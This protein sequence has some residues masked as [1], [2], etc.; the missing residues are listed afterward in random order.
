VVLTSVY[1][2]FFLAESLRVSGVL[3][4]VTLGILVSA[5]VHTRMSHEGRHAHH[6]VLAQIGYTCNHVIFFSGGIISARFMWTANECIA[7][8]KSP[9]AWLELLLLYLCS[10][11][12]RALVIAAFS[13]ILTR[14]GYGITWKEGAI[15]VW[16]GLRGAVGLAMGLMVEHQAFVDDRI[17]ATVAFHVSG[18]V[19]LTLI[20]NGMTVDNLYRRLQVYPPNPFSMTYLRKSLCILEAECGK[21]ILERM[22]DDWFFE[23]IDFESILACVPNFSK[24]AFSEARVPYPDG[25]KSVKETLQSLEAGASHFK[26]DLQQ[27]NP[28]PFL[29]SPRGERLCSWDVLKDNAGSGGQLLENLWEVA[30]S[31]SGKDHVANVVNTGDQRFEYKA[32][33]SGSPHGLY[34]S[35]RPLS[36][37]SA[38]KSEKQYSFS[39]QVLSMEG[40][41]VVVGLLAKPGGAS[42]TAAEAV[43]ATE[44]E[45]LLGATPNSV[46]LDCLTGKAR[47]SGPAG[48]GE[49][50]QGDPSC[51]AA[52]STV[53]I[54]V[55][56]EVGCEWQI[57]FAIGDANCRK[58]A[59]CTLGPF[60]PNELYPAV[61]FCAR[62]G[63]LVKGRTRSFSRL[64]AG[65]S[66]PALGQAKGP[67]AAVHLSYEPQMATDEESL[68]HL[69]H[70]IFNMIT[71][72]YHEMHEH[73]L[74]GNEA[75]SWLTEAVESAV[76]CAECEVNS[77]RAKHF[78][79]LQEM[80]R[81]PSSRNCLEQL[82]RQVHSGPD[83]GKT[84]LNL[85]EPIIVEYLAIERYCATR[86]FFERFDSWS[87]FRRLDYHRMLVKVESLWAFVEAHEVVLRKYSTLE[88]FPDLAKCL[89]VIVAEAKHDLKILAEIKPRRYWYGKHFLALRVLMTK[90]RETLARFAQEGWLARDD[91][92]HLNK[93]LRDRVQEVEYFIPQLV[94][95]QAVGDWARGFYIT[96]PTGQ[97]EPIALSLANVV[98]ASTNSV[99]PLPPLAT[100]SSVGQLETPSQRE[101][102]EAALGLHELR[103]AESR[104]DTPQL[105]LP[106]FAASPMAAR[107]PALGR[108]FPRRS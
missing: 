87:L 29:E 89:G 63:T 70:V 3:A 15:L 96:T 39:V 105:Q 104:L 85:F 30:S 44:C 7:L 47:F 17:S 55:T 1:G 35:G 16:G 90:K 21:A 11:L 38:S 27:R 73:G 14:L 80:C 92:A 36:L 42:P 98:R 41:Q 37:L 25:I 71:H 28:K 26:H 67:G 23:D 45:D 103:P 32:A 40:A 51:V 6:V 24:V 46:G 10:H 100:P 82:S 107:S 79:R 50:P 31:A 12:M 49:L 13:P 18:I 56:R 53:H 20:V 93:S 57:S 69:F 76:D 19:L 86:S 48:T 102:L 97:R 43:E 66:S 2:A 77:A 9:S 4:V 68:R 58:L 64:Q 75:L 74:I 62:S 72:H 54:T 95:T 101:R 108:T 34:V 52:G 81:R 5:S 91:C 22:L 106:G 78:S 84:Y 83:S 94:Q 8:Y 65:D 33:D 60:P 61:Q 88:R 99:V 59:D